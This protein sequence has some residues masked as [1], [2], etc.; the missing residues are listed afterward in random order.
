[1]CMS[2]RSPHRLGRSLRSPRRRGLAGLLTARPGDEGRLA[3]GTGA[4]AT[5]VVSAVAYAVVDALVRGSLKP[6]AAASVAGVVAGVAAVALRDHALSAS[7]ER[8]RLCCRESW[9]EVLDLLGAALTQGA[10]LAEALAGLSEGAPEALRRPFQV[11]AATYSLTGR[12]DDALDRLQDELGDRTGDHLVALIRLARS[13]GSAEL[14]TALLI[15]PAS[16]RTEASVHRCVTQ[17]LSWVTRGAL[18]LALLPWLVLGASRW[19]P[20]RLGAEGSNR[21]VLLVGACLSGAAGLL[22]YA[23]RRVPEGARG[24]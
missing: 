11:F 9:P 1:M 18:L 3:P 8:R 17:C 16:L 13:A 24:W 4:S 19:V 20:D 5:L 2:C 12:L 22:G 6:W 15:Q 14:T 23:I 21:S 10:G 7:E